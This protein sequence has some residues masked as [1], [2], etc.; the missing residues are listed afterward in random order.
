MDNSQV[1]KGGEYLVKVIH[2]THK[3][4]VSKIPEL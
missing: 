3:D 1:V 4:N 2:I